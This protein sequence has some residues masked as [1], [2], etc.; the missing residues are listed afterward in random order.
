MA[1]FMKPGMTLFRFRDEEEL[2]R[3]HQMIICAV[4]QLVQPEPPTCSL[5]SC[6]QCIGGFISP[7][8]ARTLEWIADKVYDL[9]TVREATKGAGA[10]LV[11]N[12]ASPVVLFMRPALVI[13]M[14]S[15]CVPRLAYMA[16]LSCVRRCFSREH[17]AVPTVAHICS[18]DPA[19]VSSSTTR[20]YFLVWDGTLASVVVPLLEIAARLKSMPPKS[21]PQDAAIYGLL[22]D[23]WSRYFNVEQLAELETELRTL[24]TCGNDERWGFVKAQL[25]LLNDWGHTGET[26]V[27]VNQ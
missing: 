24:P 20:A 3:E 5:C 17:R 18:F 14:H 10:A 25:G 27:T 8:T 19:E 15:C 16:V 2:E 9:L 12:L 22:F 26:F 6:E 1:S 11:D 7:R 21:W 4:N 23:W 13:A